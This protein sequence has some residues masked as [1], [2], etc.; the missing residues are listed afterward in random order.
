MY[1]N[2]LIT[3]FNG[4]YHMWMIAM[5]N[6][7]PL[8]FWCEWWSLYV[9]KQTSADSRGGKPAWSRWQHPQ[10]GHSSS[11]RTLLALFFKKLWPADAF[12]FAVHFIFCA[13][14]LCCTFLSSFLRCIF[15]DV[16]CIDTIKMWPSDRSS[17]LYSSVQSCLEKITIW[18]DCFRKASL[19]RQMLYLPHYWKLGHRESAAWRK[20]CQSCWI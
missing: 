13:F 1:G 18:P 8:I 9:G 11:K 17:I 15:F 7:F 2:L 19:P 10:L 16:M 5:F 3:E 4:Q 20:N 6:V 14:V 12:Q